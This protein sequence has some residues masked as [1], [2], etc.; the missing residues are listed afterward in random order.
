[1]KSTLSDLISDE[2]ED[3]RPQSLIDLAQLKVK[4]NCE[5]TKWKFTPCNAT[6]GEGHRWKYRQIIVSISPLFRLSMVSF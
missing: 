4:V 6:C 2:D 5:V 1:M 3:T